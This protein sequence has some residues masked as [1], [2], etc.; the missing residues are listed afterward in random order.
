M[1]TM[2]IPNLLSGD[3]TEPNCGLS[4]EDMELVCR[5]ATVVIHCAASI[6][7]REPLD[8]AVTKNITGSNRRPETERVER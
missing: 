6:D 3:V 2:A 1:I 7:F 8:Q 5:E 4:P